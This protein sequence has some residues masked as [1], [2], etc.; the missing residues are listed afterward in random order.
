MFTDEFTTS[1]TK[2]NIKQTIKDINSLKY[3]YEH[4]FDV[5]ALRTFIMS[6]LLKRIS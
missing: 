5:F 6:H 4:L 2:L 3:C 1:Q